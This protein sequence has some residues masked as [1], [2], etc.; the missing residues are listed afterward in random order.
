MSKSTIIAES[1]EGTMHNVRSIT[2]ILKANV[3][4]SRTQTTQHT[5]IHKSTATHQTLRLKTWFLAGGIGLCINPFMWSQFSPKYASA[6]RVL[7]SI[8]IEY[9]FGRP[10]L[11][12][13][14]QGS[15]AAILRRSCMVPSSLSAIIV[16]FDICPITNWSKRVRTFAPL[17]YNCVYDTY[18]SK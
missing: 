13:V 8:W 4:A 9:S 11:H 18:L 5:R 10:T 17:D 2:M 16:L 6:Y 1:D 15:A 7:T 12:S 14:P 3:R